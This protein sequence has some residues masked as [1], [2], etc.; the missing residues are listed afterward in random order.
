MG[1]RRAATGI[2]TVALI[3]NPNTGKSTLFNRLTGSRQRIGN[4][5]GVTVAKKSGR[6]ILDGREINVL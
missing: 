5:P 6:M 4:Y 3:G 1:N 2:A